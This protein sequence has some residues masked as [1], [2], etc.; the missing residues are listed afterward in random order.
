MKDNIKKMLQS[1]RICNPSEL[2]IRICNPLF[3]IALQCLY[4]LLPDC[5]SGRTGYKRTSANALK[6]IIYNS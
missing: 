5:K 3:F 1:C 4:S 6:V 2:N